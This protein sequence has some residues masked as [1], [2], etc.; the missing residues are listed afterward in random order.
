M[1]LTK[2]QLRRIIRETAAGRRA[3]RDSMMRNIRSR[4]GEDM[5]FIDELQRLYPDIDEIFNGG[6]DE[7]AGWNGEWVVMDEVEG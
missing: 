7:D 5:D 3:A 6:W 4:Q 2:R 1:R